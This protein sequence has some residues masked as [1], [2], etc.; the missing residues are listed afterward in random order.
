MLQRPKSETGNIP[1]LPVITSSD[2]MIR[3]PNQSISGTWVKRSN[4]LSELF[5][6]VLME[7]EAL[8]PAFLNR[9]NTAED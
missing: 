8:I 7:L 9:S 3:H 4:R 6:A 5:K 1:G 2:Q